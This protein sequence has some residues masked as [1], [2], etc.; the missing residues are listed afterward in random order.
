[1]T[2]QLSCM[3]YP[4]QPPLVQPGDAIQIRD[5]AGVW[6]PA[7]CDGRP[8]FDT[9]NALGWRVWLTVRVGV[10][11]SWVNWPAEHV[12]LAAENTEAS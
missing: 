1:V 10:G 2:R 5:V 7:R 6:H 9:E 8:R 11:G 12:R 3:P 4:G